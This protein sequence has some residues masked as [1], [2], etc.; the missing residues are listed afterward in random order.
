VSVRSPLLSASWNSQQLVAAVEYL[1]AFRILE[2]RADPV[3][4]TP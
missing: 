4:T 2:D 3:R 1:P